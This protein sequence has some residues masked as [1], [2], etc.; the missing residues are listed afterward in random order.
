MSS[1]I[2]FNSDRCGGATTGLAT[3]DWGLPNR[4]SV[5]AQDKLLLLLKEK[6][7]DLTS[8]DVI[9]ESC[10]PVQWSDAS[11]GLPEPGCFYAQVITPG[12]RIVF[13]VGQEQFTM[14]TNYDG[15]RIVSPNFSV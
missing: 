3:G 2:D 1:S 6:Y 7:P 15:S 4:Q 9:F 11:L 12:Y 5:R 10:T 13:R 8:K 14:H